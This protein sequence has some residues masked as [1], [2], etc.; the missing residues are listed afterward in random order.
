MTS[1]ETNAVPTNEAG[2]VALVVAVA[3]A[4]VEP[5]AAVV[6]LLL[7]AAFVALLAAAAVAVAGVAAAVVV[8]VVVLVVAAVECHGGDDDDEAMVEFHGGEGDV[9]VAGHGGTVCDGGDERALDENDVRDAATSDDES[10]GR[11]WQ[12]SYTVSDRSVVEHC[13]S[14]CYRDCDRNGHCEVLSVGSWLAAASVGVAAVGGNDGWTMPFRCSCCLY[15]HSCPCH[16]IALVG[17]VVA[18]NGLPV[19]AG[20]AAA[21]VVTVH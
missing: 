18:V 13:G 20:V 4:V 11:W 9:A 7:A 1:T 19:A 16:H 15:W 12:L 2:E 6:A 5:A 21:A 17:H 14:C 3:A 10:D 8:A